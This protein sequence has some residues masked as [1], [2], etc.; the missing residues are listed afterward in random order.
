[1]I[2]LRKQDT[3][4]FA[5]DFQ[6]DQ[7]IFDVF[8]P[9]IIYSSEC[10][11]CFWEGHFGMIRI[12][13][14]SDHGASICKE[15]DESTLDNVSFGLSYRLLAQLAA[16]CVN[17]LVNSCSVHQCQGTVCLHISHPRIIYSISPDIYFDIWEPYHRP[18]RHPFSLPHQVC[19]N[20]KYLPS[21][22][23]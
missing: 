13:G 18:G 1:M 8:P 20:E 10:F 11:R 12:I 22:S 4:N 21:N 2:S 3:C 19:P 6:T 14:H 23:G 9:F 5:E 15:T 7:L 17:S 16:S